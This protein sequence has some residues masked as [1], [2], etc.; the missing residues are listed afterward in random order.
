[1]LSSAL[2]NDE[3]FQWDASLGETVTAHFLTPDMEQFLGYCKRASKTELEDILAYL[4]ERLA[5]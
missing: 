2:S 3:E 1:M 4:D 5:S